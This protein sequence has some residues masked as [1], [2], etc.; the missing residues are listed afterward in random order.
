MIKI[1]KIFL[2]YGL[3][4]SGKRNNVLHQIWH[5]CKLS[6]KLSSMFSVYSL[7]FFK[8]YFFYRECRV[9]PRVVRSSKV[10]VIKGFA[11]VESP[12][13]W[14]LGTVRRL[15]C[16]ERRSQESYIRRHMD[17]VDF[18]F[19]FFFW[20]LRFVLRCINCCVAPPP[21]SGGTCLS[22]EASWVR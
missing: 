1:F 15:F 11:V 12:N 18:S 9:C 20:L 19:F 10:K 3:I 4:Y 17:L 5:F 13:L 14:Q 7:C 16:G 2:T 8:L 22:S 6:M 21:W